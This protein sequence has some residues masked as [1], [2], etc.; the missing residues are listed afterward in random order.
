MVVDDVINDLRVVVAKA[1][2]GTNR[3]HSRL[4]GLKIIRFISIYKE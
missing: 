2:S 3:V 4:G 1:Y